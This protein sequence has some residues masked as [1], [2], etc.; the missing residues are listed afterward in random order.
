M[1][2][3]GWRNWPD[4]MILLGHGYIFYIEFKV[5]D[6]NP[7]KAQWY[8][9]RKLRE[10]GYH[11]YVCDNLIEAKRILKYEMKTNGKAPLSPPLSI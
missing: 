1:E 3:K 10:R 2:I 9:I 11:V 6:E 4:R 5:P 8:R 7:R